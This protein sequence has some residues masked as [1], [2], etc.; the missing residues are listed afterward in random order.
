MNKCAALAL[1][2]LALGF[3]ACEKD[4]L[5]EGEP[6]LTLSKTFVLADGKDEVVMKVTVGGVDVTENATFYKDELSY[7]GNTFSTNKAGDYVFYAV[8]NNQNT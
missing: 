2:F 5:I 1:L 7:D 8:Y 3:T 4:K 6:G